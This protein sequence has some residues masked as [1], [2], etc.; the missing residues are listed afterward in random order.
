MIELGGTYPTL[1]EVP[2]KNLPFDSLLTP[3][4]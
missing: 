4:V 2:V 3:T 1:E